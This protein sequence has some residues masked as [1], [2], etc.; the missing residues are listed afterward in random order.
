MTAAQRKSDAQGPWLRAGRKLLA[1]LELERKL[2]RRGE[3]REAAALAPEKER[4]AQELALPTPP[5]DEAGKDLAMRLQ[6]A[7]ARNRLLLGACLDAIRAARERLQEIEAARQNLG[8]Y[9]AL[10]EK[11]P[12]RPADRL[13]DR[14]A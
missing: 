1:M 2:L 10:G 4:L 3:L 7:A 5:L 6:R 8:V 14:R 13:H 12:V 11:A 9:D